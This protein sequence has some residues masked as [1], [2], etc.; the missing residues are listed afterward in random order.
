MAKLIESLQATLGESLP[1]IVGALAILV[2]GWLVAII[3]R[4]VI[5]RALG[6][7]NVNER[8][9][10]GTGGRMDVESGVASGVYYVLLILVFLAFFDAL[11]LDL[12]SKPLQALVGNVF[13]YVPRLAAGGVLLLVAWM[14]ATVVRELVTRA[15]GAAQL[16]EKLSRE[17]GVQPISASLGNV[18]YWLVFLLFLPAILGA[19][20]LKGIL[21]P[22]QA[23]VN[24]VLNMLP[25]VLAAA[26]IGVVGWG[27]AMIVRNLVTNLLAGAGADRVGESVGLRGTMPL[28]RL[29][30]LVAYILVL[31]PALIAAL[32]AL[33]ISAIT[34][35]ATEMLDA[36]MLAIPNIFAAGVI[37]G[38]AYLVSRLVANL[39]SDLLGG[40][41]FDL[42]PEKLGIAQAFSGGT[43]PSQL[44]GRVLIF[45]VMLF[46]SVEAANRLGFARMADLVSIFIHFAGE[47][48]LGSVIIA[49]GFWLSNL[50]HGAIMRIYGNQ[51]AAI[52]N[53]ARFGIMGL[54]IAMGLRQ[55]GL[56]EDIVNLAFGLTL[57]AVAVAVALSFGLGGR[58]AA[59]KQME[60]WLS[61][62]RGGK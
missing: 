39:M 37:L 33:E 32:N 10:S 28:S 25:N 6:L 59:G 51:G 47:V 34:A 12:V 60:H 11:Q 61:K 53:V 62:L 4:A 27:L 31:L 49:V 18:L 29:V 44:V 20:E 40:I 57:G 21:A 8:I 15:L 26:V 23:M 52:A 45:F 55:M 22:V 1:G 19:L 54:V 30:G 16:D 3:I 36:V 9:R 46:A 5:R 58:E 17:A 38:I 35:P 14:L 50:A 43:T 42:L 7:L 48:L 24:E 2:V 56:A 13:D 41:G